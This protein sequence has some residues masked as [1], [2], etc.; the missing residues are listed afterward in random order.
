M[1][2]GIKVVRAKGHSKKLSQNFGGSRIPLDIWKHDFNLWVSSTLH[3]Y[4]TTLADIFAKLI[5]LF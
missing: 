2:S 3:D 5:E 4:Y 1:P